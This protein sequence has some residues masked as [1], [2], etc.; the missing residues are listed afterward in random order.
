LRRNRALEGIDPMESGYPP[1]LP[2]DRETTGASVNGD[3]ELTHLC[4]LNLTLA[5]EQ[6][7]GSIFV[8]APIAPI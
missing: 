5:F 1:L 4:R 7:G 3:V 6:S 8:G 2:S